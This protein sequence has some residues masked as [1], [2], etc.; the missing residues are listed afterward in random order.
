MCL[1]KLWE[2]IKDLFGCH[3]ED[4]PIPEWPTPYILPD[5]IEGNITRFGL[6][7]NYINPK[8]ENR[9]FFDLN[10]KE[11]MDYDNPQKDFKIEVANETHSSGD[12]IPLTGQSIEMEVFGLQKGLHLFRVDLV[13]YIPVCDTFAHH[14]V[15]AIYQINVIE[16]KESKPDDQIVEVQ[17]TKVKNPRKRKNS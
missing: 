8:N 7:N 1:S 10:A 4:N 5:V 9:I 11:E 2:K 6:S 13:E 15:K 14:H 17:V 16:K 3:F 12:I